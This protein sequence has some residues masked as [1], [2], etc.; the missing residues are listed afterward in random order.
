[1][2]VGECWEQGDQTDFTSKAWKTRDG[3]EVEKE[4][5]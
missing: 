5:G 3:N 4:E 1:M 2:T